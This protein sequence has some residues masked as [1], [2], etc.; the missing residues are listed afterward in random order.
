MPFKIYRI[1]SSVSIG[2]RHVLEPTPIALVTSRVEDYSNIMALGWYTLL[3]LNPLLI[4]CMISTQCYS[5][6]LIQ[7]SRQCVINVPDESMAEV[8]WQIGNSTGTEIDKFKTFSLTPIHCVSVQAPMI[9][10]CFA[11]FECDLY[12]ESAIKDYNFFV[13][14]VRHAHL[15]DSIDTFRTLHYRGNGEF[16]RSGRY[17]K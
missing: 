6:S 9:A 5:N 4:G 13:F 10:E 17:L 8:V 11:S 2:V 7:V 12:E 14:E 1:T 16:S 15:A 3:D